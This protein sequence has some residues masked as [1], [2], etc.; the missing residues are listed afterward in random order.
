MT[1]ENIKETVYTQM[2]VCG[3][4]FIKLKKSL[5]HLYNLNKVKTD[6]YF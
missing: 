5:I 1:A 3:E 6:K 2:C 4:G